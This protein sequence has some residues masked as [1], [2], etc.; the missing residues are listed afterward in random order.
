MRL[1]DAN[2]LLEDMGASCMP[3]MEKGIS[4][5][6]GDESSIKDYIDHAPTVDA[7]PVVRCIDCE[8]AIQIAETN[9]FCPR[10]GCSTVFDGYCHKGKRRQKD[11]GIKRLYHPGPSPFAE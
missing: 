6:T 7:V 1:I 4:Q 8:N 5:V 10:I 9:L 3:I 11:A 2:R